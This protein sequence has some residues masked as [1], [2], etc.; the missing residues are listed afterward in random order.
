MSRNT[1][2]EEQ[3]SQ[4]SRPSC[5][6]EREEEEKEEVSFDSSSSLVSRRDDGFCENFVNFVRIFEFFFESKNVKMKHREERFTRAYVL[7]VLRICKTKDRMHFVLNI[8]L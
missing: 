8:E 2:N 3:Q 6:S 4:S 7:N 1:D 5:K